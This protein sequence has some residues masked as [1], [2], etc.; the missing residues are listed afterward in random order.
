M[1]IDLSSPIVRISAAASA[2]TLFIGSLAYG[3]CKS[4]KCKKLEKELKEVKDIIED[5]DRVLKDTKA[6]TESN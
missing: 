2:A 6:E 1:N 5:A 4:R 3:I